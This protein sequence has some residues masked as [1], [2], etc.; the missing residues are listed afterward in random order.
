MKKIKQVVIYPGGFLGDSDCLIFEEGMWA[1]GDIKNG[2]GIMVGKGTGGGVISNADLIKLR[3]AI[4]R[5]LKAVPA[6]TPV[7]EEDND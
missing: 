5:H 7:S 3:N 1:T 4:N 2:M 6:P